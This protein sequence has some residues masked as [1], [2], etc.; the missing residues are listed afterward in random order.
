[1]AILN[2]F[3]CFINCSGKGLTIRKVISDGGGGGGGGGWGWGFYEMQDFFLHVRW[4][5]FLFTRWLELFF[6]SR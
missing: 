2:S 1:M 6:F 3:S 5:S 4:K